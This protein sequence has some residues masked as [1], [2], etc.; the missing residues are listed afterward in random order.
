MPTDSIL[1][2]AAVLAMFL[3]FAGTLYWADLQTPRPQPAGRDV[4]RRPF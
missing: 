3:V 1:V 2:S 4:K